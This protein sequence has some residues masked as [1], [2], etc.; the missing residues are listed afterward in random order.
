MNR[1]VSILPALVL[2]AAAPAHAQLQMVHVSDGWI[3]FITPSTPAAG[4]F[5]VTN[6]GARPVVINGASSPACGMLMLHQ[7][8]S[9][10]GTERMDMVNSVTI[11]AHGKL[12]FEPG[13]YHLMCTSPSA[14]MAP[15]QHVAVTLRFTDGR[16]I[17]KPFAVR[18]VKG[19]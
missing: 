9:V 2:A 8:K 17:T 15:G 19:E 11:P 13:G 4:Y 5:T 18:G 6:A 14:S 3:R 10:G 1:F 12:S 7:S 16:A